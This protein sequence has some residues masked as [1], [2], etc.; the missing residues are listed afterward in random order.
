M[1]T[2]IH[3]D[4]TQFLQD[5]RVEK[6][7]EFT[8]T[9]MGKPLGNYNIPI[10][11]KDTLIELLCNK[12]A[13]KI[14]V[15]LT[16]R[17][18]QH[19]IIK[20]DLDFKF[21]IE[22][23]SRKYTLDHIKGMVELYNK[24]IATYLEVP[25]D[26]IKAYVFERDAP[27][28]DKG[29]TKD[30]VHIMYPY[31]VCDTAIQHL[32]REY[33]LLH[34]PA[35][36]S[37]LEC[38]NNTDDIVD[39]QV[40]SSNNWLM[41]GCSKP[42]AKPYKLSHIFDYEFNDLN[43]K[44][45]D[46]KTLMSLLSIRDH[47]IE[48]SIQIK[49]EHK[50]LLDAKAQK[51]Q[52][53]VK[54]AIKITK[55]TQNHMHSD[56][57]L[58][59]VRELA[60]SLDVSRADSYKTWMEVGMCLHNIDPSLLDSWIDFSR[61]SPKFKDGTCEELWYNLGSRD[62]GLGIGSLH[63][64][65]QMDN[66]EAY[67]SFNKNN[68]RNEILKSQSSTTQDVAR[69]VYIK[70]RYQY[71]C[72]SMK[73]NVWYEFKSHKW[74]QTDSGV[75][76]RKKI[77]N[78][79]VNDYLQIIQYYNQSA[80]EQQDENK[81]RFLQIAKNLTDITYK[82]RDITFKNK[83]LEECKLMFYDGTFTSGL[84]SNPD[85]LGFENGVYDLKVGEFRDGRPEDLVSLSTGNDYIEY[86]E[87]DDNIVQ[88]IQFMSQVFPDEEVRDYV[89]ILLSSLI[90]GR[91]PNE[92]FHIWTGV[93]GNGKSK[94]LELFESAFGKY[95]AKIPVTVLTQKTRATSNQANP[96]ISRL[97]GIR[98]ISAQEPEENEK[99]NVG[100]IKEWTGGD[101]I[102]C[103]ALYGEQFEFKPQFKMI[104]CCNHLPSLPPDDEGTWRRISVV[105]F[106]SRFVDHPDPSNPYE[107]KKDCHLTEKLIA[108]REAFMF[109]LLEHYKV[110]QKS[111]LREPQAV[112]NATKE[113]QKTNDIYSEF[114]VDCLVADA[115][116]STR[117]EDVYRIFKDWWKENYNGKSPSRKDMKVYLEKK[118]GKYS[119]AAKGGWKGWL[120]VTPASKHGDDEEHENVVATGTIE[121]NLLANE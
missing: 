56:I 12:L 98:T 113:Y 13:Q 82:L 114:V 52:A 69:V 38:K 80:F 101:K 74:M 100:V 54:R 89:F 71:V 30:G 50:Y 120:L 78:E 103:R 91:N 32:M 21:D 61:K 88:I 51:A 49:P 111:G 104:F 106:K 96:E 59:S 44:K 33:V 2:Q 93:G 46:N 23:N 1:T 20:I 84:D 67:A 14:P 42:V 116:S 40:I 121:T 37:T 9:S 43:I 118:L 7:S 76:L 19:T 73:A 64:W 31:I 87:D 85:L 109:M 81:D 77:G 36:L 65:A 57:N 107:F 41:Y 90:E 18:Q 112:K 15:H 99:L 102:S 35:V 97:K 45:Y 105:E 5:Y 48:K 11:K 66:P 119:T 10:D 27:Y 34:C 68:L 24:A 55:L 108:W 94:L 6:G 75:S 110:Y 26:Q 53:P 17:P 70:Y 3:D 62:D 95:A 79:V 25:E 86:R 63:R 92:K 8:H 28:K 60:K 29:N 4:L 22:Q 115:K 39:K 117:L 72:T 16:E 47:S 83:I 58:E